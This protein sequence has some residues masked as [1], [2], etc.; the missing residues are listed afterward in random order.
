MP[1]LNTFRSK[2]ATFAT[3]AL[4]GLQAVDVTEAG[5]PEDVT[6]DA[7]PVIKGTV[8]DNI[9]EDIAVTCEDL[10]EADNAAMDVGDVGDLV[11]LFEKR[12]SGKG[13][14]SAGDITATWANAVLVSKTPRA[15]TSGRSQV[16]YTFRAPSVAWS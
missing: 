3:I 14:A 7:D 16:V 5:T 9:G 10:S 2:T 12:A 15:G 1:D 4:L 6:S 8:V 13:A 11:V